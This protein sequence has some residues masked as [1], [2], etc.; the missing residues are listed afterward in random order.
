MEQAIRQLV[1]RAVAPGKVIDIF[2]AAGIK[3]PDISILSDQFLAEVQGLPQKNLAVELLRRLLADELKTRSKRNLVQSRSF[4]EM[5]EKAVRA[6]QNRALETAKIIE[7][8]IKLAKE[9][10]EATRRGQDLGLTDDEVPSTMH[11][12]STTRL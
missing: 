6:Y 8:L 10:R 12:R 7:E 3:K 11:W 4:A 9:M 2:A 5:L 1:S